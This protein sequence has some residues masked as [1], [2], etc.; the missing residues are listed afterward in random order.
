MLGQA[1][2]GIKVSAVEK[3]IGAAMGRGM[4][5]SNERGFSLIELMVT[6]AV[7]AI[8]AAIALPSFTGLIRSNRLT[9]Q[10]NELVVAL[11]SARMEAIRRNV[12]VIFCR[13]EDNATC[14]NADAAWTGWLVGTD[15]NSDGAVDEVL[16][17]GAVPSQV[18]VLASSNLA[19]NRD[20]VVFRPNG[21]AQQADGSLLNASLQTCMPVTNPSSNALVVWLASGGRVYTSSANGGGACAQP[22]N[23]CSGARCNGI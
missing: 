4:T 21:L 8:I 22:A 13:T 16:R 14:A 19:D 6:V 15:T 17:V 3:G 11:Q 12:R 18:E 1:G 7:L 5:K 10:S 23:T 20:V 9:T 2:G